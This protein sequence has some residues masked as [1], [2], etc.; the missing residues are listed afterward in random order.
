[1]SPKAKAVAKRTSKHEIPMEMRAKKA[2]LVA[3]RDQAKRTL[4]AVKARDNKEARQRKKLT[5]EA[6]A[7]PL[8]LLRKV[9]QAKTDLP[10][11]ICPH[12]NVSMDCRAEMTAAFVAVDNGRAVQPA[13]PPKP[14]AA[15]AAPVS[16][17]GAGAGMAAAA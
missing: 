13:G 9:I 5:H 15:P 2:E 1:M 6:K 14:L 17:T 7:M 11:L 10:D 12:C 8:P 16:A 3:A 4:R